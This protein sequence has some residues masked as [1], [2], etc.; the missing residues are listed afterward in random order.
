MQTGYKEEY[1]RAMRLG[2]KEKKELEAAGIDPFPAVLNEICP[3]AQHLTAVAL[4]PS[5]IP[6]E[7]IVG[8]QSRG[9]ISAFSASF[10][11]LPEP[12]SEFAAKWI[13]L[14]SAH[15]SDTGIRDP[16]DCIEYLGRFYV[17]EGNKRV[18][19]LKHFGAVRIPAQVRRI[20]PKDID[21]PE[22]AAY[23]EFIEFN[24][25]TGIWDVQFKKPGDY[26]K[27]LSFLG[28]KPGEEWSDA[29]KKRFDSFF[30][31]F[32]DAFDSVGGKGCGLSPEEAMLLYFRI[33][34][35]EGSDPADPAEMKKR[36]APMLNDL[37]AQSEPEALT[38]STVPA[39]NEKKGVITKLILS[40]P[41]H[42]NIAFVMQRDAE[43]SAWTRG[44]SDGADYLKEALG[45]A[46]SV[47]TYC[48]ADSEPEAERILGEAAADG[49]ELVFTTTPPLLKATLKAAL[50]YPKIRFFNCSACQP[51][52]S[53]TSY[54]CRTYEGKF[55]TGLIAGAL[56]KNGLVG[57][58]GSYP[59]LGVPASINAF[60]LGVRMTAPDAKILL[61]WSSLEVDCV[62]KLWEKDVRVISNRDVPIPD[63]NYLKH[64]YYG[65]F[66]IDD[67]G[68]PKP[69]ASPVW[70]WGR[71]YENIVR[72]ALSGSLE[73]KEL[74]VNYWWGMDSGVIDVALSELV[75][76]GVRTLAH[77]FSEMLKKGE[78]DIF[79]EKLRAQDGS[80]ISDGTAPLSSLEIL[81]MD[82]LS[83]AVEG[84]IPAYGEL[85]PI[86][87]PLVKELGIDRE[88]IPPEDD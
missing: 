7:L 81:K 38:V 85:L 47:K 44:H 3:E 68:D 21:S 71:L 66:L 86:S 26:A 53:V 63:V 65:T 36:L 29:E 67:P 39:E 27:L 9:R 19:V 88:S 57:Y 64:G 72:R 75:P 34:P 84:R 8:T 33:H 17:V 61:E 45:D 70:M 13:A 69:L 24:S 18:S 82:R 56:S 51:L 25:L 78:F 62:R 28:K 12:D 15:L 20:L 59:I 79:K 54:Y 46:V 58:V 32:K 76:D 74:A 43:S 55:I 77:T 16:I 80:L 49:A 22:R 50:K 42:L 5:E 41:K 37:K 31:F 2:Q 10:R 4:P 87:R 52:S 6:E 35:Y 48:Y 30:H 40:V 1:L 83:E 11:P 14:C 60:A 23:R 73:K